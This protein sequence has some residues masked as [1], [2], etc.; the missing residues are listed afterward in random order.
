MKTAVIH[1]E[2]VTQVILQG[3]NEHEQA[4]L[5]LLAGGGGAVGVEFHKG[6]Y[7]DSPRWGYPRMCQGG[8]LRPFETKDCLMLVVRKRERADN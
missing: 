6:E 2:G 5:Q 4:A 8:W 7:D 3:E 1:V